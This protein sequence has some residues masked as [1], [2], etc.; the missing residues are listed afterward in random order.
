MRGKDWG[1]GRSGGW[2]A[3]LQ[4]LRGGEGE[5]KLKLEIVQK[6]EDIER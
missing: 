3:E 2:R 6:K 4:Y 1:G 5:E